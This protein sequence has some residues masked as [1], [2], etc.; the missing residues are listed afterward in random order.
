[1]AQKPLELIEVENY[2]S[3]LNEGWEVISGEETQELLAHKTQ[4]DEASKCNLQETSKILSM[5]GSP[6]QDKHSGTGLVFG[7]IQSGKTLSFTT[8]TALARDNNF[9]MVI[10]IAGISTILTNQSYTRLEKDLRM[11]IRKDR[12]W[13]SIKNPKNDQDMAKIQSILEEWRD[14]T[15]PESQRKTVLITVMKQK[16]HLSNLVNILRKLNLAR[17]PSLI[18]DDEADQAS[19]NTEAKANA[20][21]AKR[22]RSSSG[23][24]TSRIYQRILEL[25]QVISHHTFIQYTATPQAPLFLR[26]I[27]EVLSPNFVQLLTCGEKYTGGEVFFQQQPDLVTVIPD[28]EITAIEESPQTSSPPESL[29][30]AMRL[31]FL[32]VAKGIID[33]EFSN[34]SMM[35][36]PSQSTEKHDTYHRWVTSIKNEWVKILSLP[37]NNPEKIELLTEFQNSYKSLHKTISDLPPVQKLIANNNLLHT[38][39]GTQIERL[40]SKQGSSKGVSWKDSYS[41]ILVGGQSMDRGFTV[42]GLT[43][44]YMPRNI[45]VGNA[46]TIQQ[47]A[48][49][50]GY[51]RDY[52]GYCRVFLS[53]DAKDAYKD[54]VEHEAD[55]R[56]RLEAH[57]ATG[58]P[59]AEWYREVFLPSY[60][61]PTRGNVIYDD[62]ERSHFGEK[63]FSTNAPH[64]ADIEGNQR[65]VRDFLTQMGLSKSNKEGV[66]VPLEKVCEYLAKLKY[67]YPGDARE[68]AS[69][70]SVLKEHLE[71][72]PGAICK[73]YLMGDFEKPRQRTLK[74]D[75]VNQ[76]FQ[77][78]DQK[79]KVGGDRNVGSEDDI[80]IQIHILNLRREK[81]G[82]NFAFQ[83]V[84]ALAI[85]L[86]K[87]LA[88]DLIRIVQE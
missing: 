3:A 36:H 50:F 68:F 2:Q 33:N 49:F 25:K 48:R 39:R 24:R 22:S 4:L 65:I 54:Y 78:P 70:R 73:G 53:Q 63:W 28:K 23:D 87:N 59:L 21:R 85:W 56:R 55:M 83:Q 71:E 38:I 45:G 30:E 6:H 1:M 5:C 86:P 8:L 69:V 27:M 42:E 14:T 9:Q 60:L 67:T 20:R 12:K 58:K 16:N 77:G 64:D 11:D 79:K 32:G 47:R 43:V 31:F 66:G 51:K 80:R 75:K 44:T 82:K 35:I 81:R 26:Q 72:K 46:D 17:V 52:L 37:E 34:R 41:F 84:P 19:L 74:G 7:Y 62:L 18:I 57:I 13:F 40:N 61:E 15:F 88:R 29:Q 10:V 76:I